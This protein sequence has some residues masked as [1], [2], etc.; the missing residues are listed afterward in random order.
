MPIFTVFVYKDKSI[1]NDTNYYF[2]ELDIESHIQPEYSIKN[3]INRRNVEYNIHGIITPTALLSCKDQYC[4]G[5]NSVLMDGLLYKYDETSSKN[6]DA[7]YL[8]ENFSINLFNSVAGEYGVIN[9]SDAGI[10]TA[11]SDPERIRSLYYTETSELFAISTRPSMLARLLGSG[12]LDLNWISAVSSIG[13]GLGPNSPYQEIKAIPQD[14]A[15]IW[16]GA[17]FELKTYG[18]SLCSKKSWC[19]QK[20]KSFCF[21]FG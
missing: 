20:S 15:L 16:D 1:N 13:Y 10:L 21:R 11:L 7:N 14:N 12:R 2:R 9:I 18:P 5:N 19:F 4:I 3:T 6:I 8:A 17:R